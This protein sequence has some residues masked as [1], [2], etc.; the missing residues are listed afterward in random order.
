VQDKIIVSLINLRL[1]SGTNTEH[2]RFAAE[3]VLP[4]KKT[5]IKNFGTV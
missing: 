4:F 2:M 3:V 1:Q 5:P